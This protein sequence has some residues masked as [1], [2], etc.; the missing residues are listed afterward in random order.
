M[1]LGAGYIWPA[2]QKSHRNKSINCIWY[3]RPASGFSL[4]WLLS[5]WTLS[6]ADVPFS[7]G[8][9]ISAH[10]LLLLWEWWE[11][12]RHILG[13]NL[14]TWKNPQ[15]PLDLSLSLKLLSCFLIGNFQL[16]RI[17]FFKVSFHRPVLPHSIRQH[18]VFLVVLFIYLFSIFRSFNSPFS[19]SLTKASPIPPHT[20]IYTHRKNCIDSILN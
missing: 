7:L 3:P 4:F 6:G 1:P 5:S 15:L 14:Q 19:I 16:D 9:S 8:R 12:T 2:L 13:C 10:S 11:R 17:Q 20:Y 18:A